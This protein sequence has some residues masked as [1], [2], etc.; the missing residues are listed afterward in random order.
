MIRFIEVKNE[1]NYN[2]RME[3]R[4]HPKFGLGEVWINPKYVVEVREATGYRSLLEEGELPPS[5]H[6]DHRFS[7]ITVHTGGTRETHVVVGPPHVVAE[8]LDINTSQLLKG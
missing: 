6:R 7:H 1:T 2:P 3:R 8:K 4:A 5:L